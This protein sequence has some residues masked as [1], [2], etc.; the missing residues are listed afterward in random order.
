MSENCSRKLAVILH[1]DVVGSTGLVQK[2]EAVAHHRFQDAFQRFSETIE[3][4]GGTAREIRGDALVAEFARASDAVTAALAFQSTNEAHN[5]SLD[6]D[7]RPRIRIGI[8]LGE[9]VIADGTITGA[10][11]VLAQRLEQLAESGSVV[12]QG[13]VSETVPIRLPFEFESLGEQVLKGFDHPVRAFVARL[14]PGERLPAPESNATSMIQQD[15]Q[16]DDTEHPTVELPDKPSIAVLPFTN[17][18]GDSEQEYFSDGITEDIITGLSR[19][20]ELFVIA[21]GSSFAFKDQSVG[22]TEMADK[23]GAKYVLE[24][25][26]RKAGNRVRIT[27]QLIEGTTG[28]HLWAENYDRVLE[29]VFAVQ[30]DVSQTIIA[31]LA[32]RVEEESRERALRKSA[33][34]LSAYDYYLR[35]KHYWPDWM[36][37][38]NNILQAREMFE[39]ATE[40]DPDYAAAY[41]G[42]AESYIAEFWSSWTTNRDVAGARAFEHACKAVAL[43]DRDSHAHLILAVAYFHV[44]SNFELAEVQIQRA[45]ELNPND[46]WNYCFKTSFSLCAGDFEE[47]IFCGSEAIRRNPFLP[48]GCLHGMGF[49]EYFAQRYD[50]AIKTFGRLSAPG[51][52]VQGC[53]A[54][55]YAQLGRDEEARA[56]AAEFRDRAKA[57]LTS[58][59]NWDAE[60]WRDYWSSLFNFKDP[61]SLK[62][63][64]D[65]LR[66]AGLSE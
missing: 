5:D 3:S 51:V 15:L 20:R 39:Q 14:S 17:M 12:V 27:A 24:G 25:S 19:F 53:I 46:Y 4:Y 7:I 57:E 52:E 58:H 60:D 21:R 28:N 47:S 48:D 43:D 10:G 63:L 41:I 45:L 23:L 66:K 56:A 11:V 40:L 62:H 49:S 22:I 35:G 38:K 42:L 30:D 50:N 26:V 31:T 64:L 55:C 18:S 1:A 61:G 54:A 44:K 16:D 13:T 2:N 6:D 29:D 9:V 37:S 33:K 65:G 8:S 34:N 59:G 32:G 36:G